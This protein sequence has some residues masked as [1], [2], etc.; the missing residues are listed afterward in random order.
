MKDVVINI[1]DVKMASALWAVEKLAMLLPS[2]TDASERQ[3]IR[4]KTRSLT[5]RGEKGKQRYSNDEL[6]L[7]PDG[8]ASEK[9]VTLQITS[10][11][12]F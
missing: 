6:P 3:N 11:G 2:I 10:L 4:S 8:V 12:K 5:D 1:Q 9:L 7:S